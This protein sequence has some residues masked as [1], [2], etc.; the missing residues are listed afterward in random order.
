MSPDNDI[1]QRF[2]IAVRLALGA[3]R[4]PA[5]ADCLTPEVIAAYYV[6][7]LN[8]VERSRCEA[9]ISECGRCQETLDALIHAKPEDQISPESAARVAEA[10]LV[11]PGSPPPWRLKSAPPPAFDFARLWHTVG[12]TILFIAI[13][14]VVILADVHFRQGMERGDAAHV[15]A[16]QTRASR[17]AR[18]HA[19]AARIDREDD[20]LAL[21]EVRPE[22][23]ARAPMPAAPLVQTAAGVGGAAP[24]TVPSAP[25]SV[26]SNPLFQSAPAAGSAQPSHSHGVAEAPA[27]AKAQSPN[28]QPQPAVSAIDQSAPA[29]PSQAAKPAVKPPAKVASSNTSPAG[30]SSLAP[31]VAAPSAKPAEP[32]V[33]G[34]PPVVAAAPATETASAAVVA[35]A[36]PSSTQSATTS[37]PPAETPA[38]AK[39]ASAHS[40]AV[41]QASSKAST[42]EIA[43]EPPHRPTT[44]EERQL[45]KSRTSKLASNSLATRR[46]QRLAEPR[47]RRHAEL[48]ARAWERREARARRAERPRSV[49]HSPAAAVHIPRL[50][51]NR[52]PEI[53]AAHA[54]LVVASAPAQAAVLPAVAPVAAGIPVPPRSA[55]VASPRGSVYWS[56]Q[57]FG[58]IYRSTDRR[59]WVRMPSGT[60][61]DLLAGAA[62]S[63][64]VCWAVGSNGTVLLTKD[65]TH[66]TTIKSPTTA[67]LVGVTAASADVATIVARNGRHFS[68]FDG[69]SNWQRGNGETS[70]WRHSE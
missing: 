14:A 3:S 59:S 68:T 5:S 58:I 23:A 8:R 48:I 62:P 2:E 28:S 25:R 26:Y 57:D 30:A 53:G 41:D 54:D 66:W 39:I 63:P 56:F 29:A 1:E 7:A 33:T 24:A 12:P 13:L 52:R 6:Y 51:D 16:V 65:G 19:L 46:T 67:D 45:A 49:A 32:S 31:S 50:A 38:A 9:H 10:E 20:E 70:A 47:R 69:G 64:T 27:Q 61:D 18:R 42:P 11:E 22:P 21:N 40:A 44:R 55:L 15:A 37:T 36:K 4:R 35:P 34:A 43:S 17:R 60:Q